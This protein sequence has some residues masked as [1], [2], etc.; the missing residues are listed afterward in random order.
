MRLGVIGC[1]GH[2][3]AVRSDGFREPTLLAEHI[4]EV[5]A[6]VYIVGLERYGLVDETHR[7]LALARL[8]RGETKEMQRHVMVRLSLEDSSVQG[9]SLLQLTRLMVLHGGRQRCLDR[10]GVHSRVEGWRRGAAPL[11]LRLPASLLAVHVSLAKSRFTLPNLRPR[12]S[13]DG[14][15]IAASVA[16]VR[17]SR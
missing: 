14:S 15:S 4:A 3:V 2:D 8:M 12:R 11:S 13:R 7:D 1:E 5:V 6:R 9:L 10:A 16:H 17:A